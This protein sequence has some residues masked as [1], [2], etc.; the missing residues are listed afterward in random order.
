MVDPETPIM[1]A[2]DGKFTVT[3]WSYQCLQHLVY[4]MKNECS[5]EGIREVQPHTSKVK[6]MKLVVSHS[7]GEALVEDITIYDH[8]EKKSFCISKLKLT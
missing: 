7:I 4:A 2:Y 8:L 1:D 3:M 5:S 6:L